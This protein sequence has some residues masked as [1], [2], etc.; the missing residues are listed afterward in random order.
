MSRFLA[1]LRSFPSSTLLSVSS[2][3]IA[4]LQTKSSGISS[5]HHI[6]WEA[7]TPGVNA[8]IAIKSV[9][10]Q[11]PSSPP[12]VTVVLT[13]SVA[14]HWLQ[15]SPAQTASLAELHAIARSRASVLFGQTANIDWDI[16][17]DWQAQQAFLCT[18]VP[19]HWN[20]ALLSLGVVHHKLKITSPLTLILTQFEK[21]LPTHGWLAI[22]AV[23]VLN[24]MQYHE[25]RMTSLRTVRLPRH[26]SS[27]GYEVIALA[28]WRREKLRVQSS[29]TQLSWL[30]LMPHGERPVHSTELITIP[31]T[32]RVEIPALPASF[33]GEAI[34]AHLGAEREALL[35]A[36]CGHQCQKGLSK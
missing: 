8:I 23:G 1:N 4:W 3:A 7:D 6:A 9:R 15:T 25:G 17:A 32:P 35:A 20:K 5:W 27:E 30:N 29:A 2:G 12:S 33:S 21:S 31:W 19:T 24:L 10:A 22:V 11:L 16:S 28:E 26:T 36:W 13:P 34:D 18:G 14:Q